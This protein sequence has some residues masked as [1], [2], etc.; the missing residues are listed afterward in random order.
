M[1]FIFC[2]EPLAVGVVA[3]ISGRAAQHLRA[4]RV[5]VGELIELQATEGERFLVEVVSVGRVYTVNPREVVSTPPTPHR[6]VTLV[7]PL[8][9]E[10]ALDMVL[11]KTT[12]LGV[13]HIRLYQADHSPHALKKDRIEHKVSRWQDIILSA[14]EQSGRASPPTLTLYESLARALEGAPHPHVVGAEGGHTSIGDV[15]DDECTY[16]VG[17]EG[18]LSDSEHHALENAES[19]CLSDYT[20]R[21]ETAAIA[22]VTYLMLRK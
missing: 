14:C 1:S 15:Y 16:I 2:T 10:Q 18:G 21:S 19:I 3:E 11:Q 20:L 17:P 22:G 6:L 9:Q 13:A 5:R 4:R 8:I 7:Q 12:E